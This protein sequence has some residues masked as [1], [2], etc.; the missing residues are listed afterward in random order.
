MSKGYTWILGALFWRIDKQSIS[1]DAV[2]EFDT[3]NVQ[4]QNVERLYMDFGCQ[5][6][7]TPRESIGLNV[8]PY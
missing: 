7:K 3:I 2:L 4:E 8:T 5:Y 6:V 1:E